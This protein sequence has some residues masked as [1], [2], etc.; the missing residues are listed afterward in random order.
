MNHGERGA[1]AASLREAVLQVMRDNEPAL[2]AYVKE[3]LGALLEQ[4]GLDVQL[5]RGVEELLERLVARAVAEQTRDAVPARALALFESGTAPPLPPVRAHLGAGG[6]LAVP[7]APLGEPLAA[8][9]ERDDLPLPAPAD[10]E[11]Y[12]GDRHLDYWLSGLDD[13]LR[14]RAT[15]AR[16]GRELAAPFVALD[17]GCASGRVLR[18][19]LCQA[20]GLE[21][22]GTDLNER[23]VHWLL[24][25]FPQALKVF[26]CTTLPSL[27]LP[28]AGL[29]LVTAYSVFTHIDEYELGWLLELRRVLRPGGIAYLSIHS[30]ATWSRL[31]PGMAVYE[32]L[33]LLRDSIADY[34][35]GP[36]LFQGPMP[37]DKTVFRWRV[38]RL[39]N[40]NV[41][42]SRRHVHEVWGRFFE[43]LE[44]VDRG[45]D[46]QDVVVL[47]RPG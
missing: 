41:F 1:A 29:D 5:S 23:H 25:H 46:Y 19:L 15:L 20:R 44:I 7:E 40:T 14:L 12:H 32:N 47:R 17:F 28:D 2:R 9:I 35:I 27:P 34:A 4:E 31:G 3:A 18:H 45:T 6:Y 38:A 33:Y 10:R 39:N 11:G 21:L 42:L 16:H 8:W 43:V 13:F 36:E 24:E 26:Q 30:D 22:W 37:R